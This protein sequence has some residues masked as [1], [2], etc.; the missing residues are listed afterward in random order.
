LEIAPLN[1]SNTPVISPLDISPGIDFIPLVTAAQN[2]V[3]ATSNVEAYSL[4]VTNGLT[5]Y[6]VG[7]GT[8]IL[9]HGYAVVNML[10]VQIPANAHQGDTYA[11]N[12]LYPSATA[13]AYN[14]PVPLTAMPTTTIVVTNIPYTVGD[15]A[16]TL[17][18]WY[19]A[20]TFGDNNLDNSDVNQAFY[21]AS[22][23]R[24]PFAFSDAFNA[25]D[26]FPLDTD[27]S[28]GGDGQ[29]RFLDWVTI[30]GR[31]LRLDP[32][33]WAREWSA[34][35][36]LMDFSTN[37]VVPRSRTTSA[38]KATP[39]ASSPWPWYRQVLLGLDSVGNV[40]PN[41][42]V[43]VPI[44]AQLADGSSLSG[45]Q[46]R[47]VVTPQ[48]GAPALTTAPQLATA[49][50]VTSPLLTQSFQ[51]GETAF[52]WSLDSFNLLSRSSNFLGWITFTV[53][54]NAV[55]GQTYQV[56]LLN[57]DGAP[58][59]T[60]QYDFETRSATVAVNAAAPPATICSDEWK[61]H[62]FGSTTNPAAADNADP[63]GD[64]VPNWMEFLAGTDPTS[65]L[66]KL[67][68]TGALATVGK[69]HT[70]MQL[71]WLTAPGRAY[72]VQWNTH[73]NNPGAWNTLSIISGSGYST[74]CPDP[75]F[76]S[77]A[78][79]YRLQLLP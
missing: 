58:N 45:L 4:G 10:E 39:K 68:L 66:S 15:S 28:V 37:L 20:G 78:R 64:G 59:A 34:G 16:S 65:A 12:V 63:D 27:G 7:A 21:A 5:S 69:S 42:T 8:H 72:V 9:F 14:D 71:N 3:T 67:H 19:N 79:F 13:D 55:A 53:P 35:G 1:S 73:L 57:A 46:F 49:T 18:T 32:D 47:A 23:L 52:G 74:N 43:A 38:P 6:A 25:M 54:T 29:I 50:G 56:S 30:L 60:N 22:G 24:V 44:Y 33:N 70:Q 31:S 26:A 76:N 62:F 2:G 40:A 36:N 75:G 61:L 17:R 48:N 41:A 51:A 77:T 11:V